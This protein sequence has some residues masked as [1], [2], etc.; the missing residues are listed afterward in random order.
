MSYCTRSEYF[1]PSPRE[2][3]TVPTKPFTPEEI[4]QVYRDLIKNNPNPE[5]LVEALYKHEEHLKG[6]IKLWNDR[7]QEK[8]AQQRLEYFFNNC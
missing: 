3:F 5:Q 8:Y 1:T 2:Y 4:K 6:I 7:K